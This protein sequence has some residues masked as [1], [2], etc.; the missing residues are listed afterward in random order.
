MEY[1]KNNEIELTVLGLIEEGWSTTEIAVSL[2]LS[3]DE[4]LKYF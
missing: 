1:T 4:I 2:S 3:E